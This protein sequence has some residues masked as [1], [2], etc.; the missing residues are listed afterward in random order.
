MLTHHT[1]RRSLH[2]AW[3][4]TGIALSSC[5]RRL[6][7]LAQVTDVGSCVDGGRL[8]ETWDAIEGAVSRRCLLDQVHYNYGFFIAVGGAGVGFG[9]GFGAG[10]VLLSVLLLLLL[11][12]MLVLM[13]VSVAMGKIDRITCYLCGQE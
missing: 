10:A 8:S 4:D 9:V 3:K 5:F 13:A 11:A 2:R 6:R 1:T 12:V 7:C